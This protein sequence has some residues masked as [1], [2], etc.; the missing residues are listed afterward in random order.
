MSSVSL[1]SIQKTV[2][3][4]TVKV[5]LVP[6]SLSNYKSGQFKLP[7]SLLDKNSKNEVACK[8]YKK[9]EIKKA[10]TRILT[11]KMEAPTSSKAESTLQK[12]SID[13]HTENNQRQHKST[14]DT[15]SLGVDTESS[16]DGDSDEDTTSSL[17]SLI[18]AYLNFSYFK[19]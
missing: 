7:K 5:C 4:K 1:R 11:S 19:I 17:V 8:K 15:V 13:V 16:Q 18:T 12:S 3:E 10:C 9:T 6:F 2:L 14:S